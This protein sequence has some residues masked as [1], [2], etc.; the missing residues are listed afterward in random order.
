MTVSLSTFELQVLEQI[1]EL[2]ASN[3]NE[4]VSYSAVLEALPAG[5]E[6]REMNTH[7][8]ALATANYVHLDER[9]AGAWL[10][11][12]TDTG[13]AALTEIRQL[14]SS[15]RNRRRQMRDDYLIWLYDQDESGSSPTADDFLESGAHFLGTP[16]TQDDLER[17]G[18]W[19]LERGFIKGPTAWQRP[20]PI[21][22]QITAKGQLYVEEEKSVHE[23]P[24]DV[25]AATFNNTFHAP[26]VLAQNSQH[27]T[28][29]QNIN[30][31][32]DDARS[33]AEAVAQLA[34]ILPDNPSL[35]I[36]ASE[37]QHEV[38]NAA[39]PSRVR[40][41]VDTIVKALGSGAGGA[42]GGA[43]VTHGAAVLASLPL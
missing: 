39:R 21:R 12:P 38:D 20:D 13:K 34:A 14:R 4:P 35:A 40:E 11:Q 15:A 29:T 18:E 3:G 19:L 26:A 36:P 28:Q 7:V 37:L 25:G 2:S 10:A 33:F 24:T 31:W 6:L 23:S 41:L 32:K 8:R 22:P 5:T 9:Y 17:T 27:V 16:Y 30:D 43:L 1:V 42:L